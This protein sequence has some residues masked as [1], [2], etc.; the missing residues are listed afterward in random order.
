MWVHLM[1]LEKRGITM[2]QDG[3]KIR[4][5]STCELAETHDEDRRILGVVG[6]LDLAQ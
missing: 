4:S 2:Y 5:D 3:E 6:I 1:G